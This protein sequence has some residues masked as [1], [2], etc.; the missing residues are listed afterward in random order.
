MQVRD[1]FLKKVIVILYTF[2]NDE[3]L[4]EVKNGEL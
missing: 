1:Y 3:G 2:P 4:Y